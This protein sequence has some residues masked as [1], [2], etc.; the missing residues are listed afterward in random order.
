MMTHPTPV[1]TVFQSP[2]SSSVAAAA[3]RP[4]SMLDDALIGFAA[5][6]MAKTAM[7]PWERS[8]LFLTTA[9][10]RDSAQLSEGD[11]A[12]RDSNQR[13]TVCALVPRNRSTDLILACVCACASQPLSDYVTPSKMGKSYAGMLD[14]IRRT[15]SE[16]VRQTQTEHSTTTGS[17]PDHTSQRSLIGRLAF[18]MRC[19]RPCAQGVLAF[20]RGNA[21]NVWR[22]APTQSLNFMVEN[23]Y[24]QVRLASAHMQW[25]Q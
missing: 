23:V 5:A 2:S 4:C 8:K 14:V 6:T 3:C 16:R 9:V 7:A 24:K 17:G 13:V 21:A 15:P 10:S 19:V 25:R 11:A 20:W 12:E 22:Y 1:P 18:A